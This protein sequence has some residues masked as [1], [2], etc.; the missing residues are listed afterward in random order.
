MIGS[1]IDGVL[2]YYD[3]AFRRQNWS[4]LD[5]YYSSVKPT[6]LAQLLANAGLILISGRRE[7]F[8][9]VTEN[10]LKLNG[11][12][13]SELLLFGGKEKD[14]NILGEWKR[15]MIE[16][17]GISMYFEDDTRIGNII[18]TSK[19]A[20][21]VMIVQNAIIRGEESNAKVN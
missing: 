12:C 20:C 8:R 9:D 11:I 7:K 21:L 2:A 4:H 1:D 5:Q 17:Y 19:H 15:S 16:K 13:W 10:W 6:V 14:R 18:R 3:P